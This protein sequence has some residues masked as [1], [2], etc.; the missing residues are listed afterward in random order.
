MSQRKLARRQAKTRHAS[1]KLRTSKAERRKR[2][3]RNFDVEKWLAIRKE[4][5][6]KINPETAEVM[7]T[8][9]QTLDPYGVDP[10]LPEELQQVG[11]EDFARSPESNIWIHFGDLPEE[12][13]N[14]LWQRHKRK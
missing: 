9:A 5:G 4:E 7:W 8:Y 1:A 13:R 6:L 10:D 12:T 2:C 3:R 11:R 14:A